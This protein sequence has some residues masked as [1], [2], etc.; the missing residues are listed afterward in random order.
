LH[1][2]DAIDAAA[3][4]RTLACVGGDAEKAEAVREAAAAIRAEPQAAPA[5]TLPDYEG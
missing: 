4:E 1:T 2:P 3:E 5:P